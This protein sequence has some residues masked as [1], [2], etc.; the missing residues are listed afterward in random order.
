MKVAVLGAGAIGAYV[1]ASLHRAGAEVHLIA[2]GPHLAAIRSSGVRVTSERGDFT[3]HPHATDDPAEVG[4][5]D[6]VFLGLKANSYATCG[7]LIEPLLAG[8]TSI[9]AAQNGIP[10]WYFHG[11]PGPYQGRRVETVD[12]GG[13]VSAVLPVHRAI[14]CVVYAA[15][16]I[17]APG[18][19]RHLEGTRLSIGEP[20]GSV[21]ARCREFSDAM[22]AGGLKCPVEPDLR[23]DIWIKLMGNIAFNPISALTR[24]TMLGI[25]KHTDTRSTVVQMM[26]ETLDVAARL[27]VHPEVSIDRRLAGAER[28]GEHKTST[29][30]DL[31]KGKPLEL[32]AILAAV[33]ELADLTGAPVPT[34]RVVNALAGLLGEQVAS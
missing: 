9:I 8:H 2:R 27:G 20:D 30:Q 33:V 26:R 19:I 11:L 29:L 5:V 14:G 12:P 13:A 4:P 1:G 24:A 7:P 16:E 32:D 3:A 28:T 17:S 22:V 25:C 21:S 18:E 23:H 15:T 10:W 31:E 34:L 6:H